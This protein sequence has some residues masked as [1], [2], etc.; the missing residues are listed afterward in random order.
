M[1]VWPPPSA[2][3][4]VLRRKARLAHHVGW[5]VSGKHWSPVGYV[6]PT[7]SI[8]LFASAMVRYLT[9]SVYVPPGS[10]APA[11]GPA[12]MVCAPT[13]ALVRLAG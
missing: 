9:S 6:R 4:P 3:V 13:V 7:A 10:T 12:A 11:K 8:G 5:T 2:A 1:R